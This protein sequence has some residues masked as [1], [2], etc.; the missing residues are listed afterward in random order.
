MES[1]IHAVYRAGTDHDDFFAECTCG[2]KLY[3]DCEWAVF[4]LYREHKLLVWA[5]ET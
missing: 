1:P 2:L 5:D 4:D 3:G